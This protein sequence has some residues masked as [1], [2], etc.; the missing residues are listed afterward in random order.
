ML[1]IVIIENG[2]GLAHDS[3]WFSVPL[4]VTGY[5]YC[6][7]DTIRTDCHSDCYTVYAEIKYFDGGVQECCSGTI[8]EGATGEDL[9][10]EFESTG[11]INME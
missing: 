8:N 11:I 4:G 5:Q 1:R 7:N 10:D 6:S 3:G 9:L 2:I